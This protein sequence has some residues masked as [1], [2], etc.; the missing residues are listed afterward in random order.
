MCSSVSLRPGF[1]YTPGVGLIVSIAY[2]LV[3]YSMW[4]LVV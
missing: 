4:V 1:F 2:L 3:Y